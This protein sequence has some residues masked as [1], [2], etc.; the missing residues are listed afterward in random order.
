MHFNLLTATR[1]ISLIY[2]LFLVAHTAA[3]FW[4]SI[5]LKLQREHGTG[6]LQAMSIDG[7]NGDKFDNYLLT[8][9]IT[10]SN[11]TM[12]QGKQDPLHW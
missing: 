10:L 5:G 11:I 6:W 8:L 12:L 3:C 7:M 9:E 4:F 2:I 1:I